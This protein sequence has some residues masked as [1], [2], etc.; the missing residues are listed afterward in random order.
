MD[1]INPFVIETAKLVVSKSFNF[2]SRNA[3][4]GVECRLEV[5]AVS[6]E[7]SVGDIIDR[8]E[9]LRS[10]DFTSAVRRQSDKTVLFVSHPRL[11]QFV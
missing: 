6:R 3:L 7:I 4:A 10:C 9:V 8:E 5:L 2:S 1:K 11:L